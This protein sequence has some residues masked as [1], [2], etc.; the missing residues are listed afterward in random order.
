MSMINTE[1]GKIDDITLLLLIS[2]VYR[3]KLEST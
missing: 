3:G 2:N 1:T